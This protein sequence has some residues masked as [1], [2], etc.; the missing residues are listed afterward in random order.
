[1]VKAESAPISIDLNQRHPIRCLNETRTAIIVIPRDKNMAYFVNAHW[2]DAPQRFEIY[3][4][5]I[6]KRYI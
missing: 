1:M 4:L 6:V 3:T 5:R 2:W